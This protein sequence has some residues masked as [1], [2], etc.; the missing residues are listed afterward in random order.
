MGFITCR[1]KIYDNNSISVE[2]INVEGLYTIKSI[3]SV[4]G[5][6]IHAKDVVHKL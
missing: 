1:N 6:L 3:I 4:E 2:G 5:R